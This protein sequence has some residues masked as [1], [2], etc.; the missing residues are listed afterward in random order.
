M[1]NL[2]NTLTTKGS[3]ARMTSHRVEESYTY[4]RTDKIQFWKCEYIIDGAF[5]I[6]EYDLGVLKLKMIISIN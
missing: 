3:G 4:Y 5:K 2:E 1:R 6:S